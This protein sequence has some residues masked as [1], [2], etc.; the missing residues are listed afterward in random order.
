MR[1]QGGS[2]VIRRHPA[3]RLSSG[4][5]FA[6]RHVTEHQNLVNLKINLKDQ[7]RLASITAGAEQ[8]IC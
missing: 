7:L 2:I 8:K 6:L 1:R 4:T 5:P 3:R